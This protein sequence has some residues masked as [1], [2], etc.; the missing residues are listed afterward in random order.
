MA[1]PNGQITISLVG[2]G[3]KFTNAEL[4]IVKRNT[5]VATGKL[6]RGWH[7][8]GRGELVNKVPYVEFVEFG[9]KH[10]AARNFVKRS[11]D[12][13]MRSVITR[14]LL[15]T[16]EGKKLLDV[17]KMKVKRSGSFQ[18]VYQKI[19]HPRFY[20]HL[21]RGLTAAQMAA[22]KRGSSTPNR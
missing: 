18:A 20:R 5:P 22:A 8:N 3:I 7:I 15:K 19:I 16:P 4:A 21:L 11:L 1:Y 2:A 6:K 14:L 12:A 13:I 10:M 9:T 17:V